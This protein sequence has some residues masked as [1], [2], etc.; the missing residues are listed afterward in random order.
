MS[1]L[2]RLKEYLTE[3]DWDVCNCCSTLCRDSTIKFVTFYGF[4]GA[5]ESDSETGEEYAIAPSAAA[6][7]LRQ[8][9]YRQTTPVLEEST[10]Q[11]YGRTA[12]PKTQAEGHR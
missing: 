8:L 4:P 11:F 12:V 9:S 6:A 3:D 1:F 7:R 5:F 10:S 2:T